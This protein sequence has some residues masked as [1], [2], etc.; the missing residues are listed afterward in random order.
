MSSDAPSDSGA[1]T[2]DESSESD[3][4]PVARRRRVVID[5][6]AEESGAEFDDPAEVFV[7]TSFPQFTKLPL[8]LRHHIW[9][10]FCPDLAL[11]WRVMQFDA[12]SASAMRQGLSAK[13]HFSLADQTEA[14]RRVLATHRESRAL[15]VAAFPD[16][17]SIDAGSGDAIV[18]FN[19]NRDIVYVHN[20]AGQEYILPNFRRNVGH[21]AVDADFDAMDVFPNLDRVYFVLD[22]D[23]H[24][25]KELHWA[26]SELTHTYT[27]QTYQKE[28]YL[29]EDTQT[30]FSWPDVDKYGS[31]AREMSD[32]GWTERMRAVKKAVD[33]LPM[34]MFSE[35]KLRRYYALKGKEVA[36][37]VSDEEEEG[38]GE[39]EEEEDEY[40]SEGINDEDLSE[41]SEEEEE[42]A[43]FSS[44]EPERKKRRAR[45]VVE[46][47]DEEDDRRQKRRRVV[48]DEGESEEEEEEE[49]EEAG[50]SLVER[51]KRAREAH[52]I[53]SDDEEDEEE[54]EVEDDSEEESEDED[55]DEEGGFFDTMADEGEDE[56]E[57]E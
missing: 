50:L 37:L 9:T 22:A 36:D 17:L 51:L 31:I 55:E 13:D 54:S 23:E 41:A 52:P 29:G 40:E 5:L 11:K 24:S 42:E 46:S 2:S 6:E 15:A 48:S 49:E 32:E 21:L 30:L 27:V 7:E 45:A 19:T 39:E 12:S 26:A 43:R 57:D 38:E 16:E 33:V 1:S 8:E 34:A 28:M 44:P 18:R 10:L 56:S 53:S 25:D 14:T 35:D 3:V 20:M 4:S 47:D